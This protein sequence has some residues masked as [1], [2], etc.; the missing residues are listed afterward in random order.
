MKTLKLILS[1]T[2]RVRF[3]IIADGYSAA[4]DSSLP[5][6][7]EGE[8]SNLFSILYALNWIPRKKDSK[9]KFN[10]NDNLDWMIK[11]GILDENKEF[12]TPNMTKLIGKKLYESLFPTKIRDILQIFLGGCS[13][14]TERLHIQIQYAAETIEKCNLSLYPWQLVHDE[15]GFLAKRK[16]VFS[17]LIA[18]GEKKYELKKPKQGR[19]LLIS[20]EATDGK[21][22]KIKSKKPIIL[23]GINQSEYINIR[24]RLS[25]VSWITDSKKHTFEE[26]SQYLIQHSKDPERPNII[27][28]DGHGV[29]K[30]RCRNP[31]CSKF[32]PRDTLKCSACDWTLPAPKG[33]L[34]FENK[35]GK[36]D[37]RSAQTF[38]NVIQKVRPVLVVIQGYFILKMRL[39]VSKPYLHR[40][41]V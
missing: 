10:T 16:V 3:S 27:H 41:S 26:L 17:H 8:E 9:P 35:L 5:Y 32:C 12:F 6:S 34:L 21:M 19:I 38:A 25:L 1:A 2:D 13:S 29:F 36:P 11:E 28:F 39:S 24:D 4:E 22:Q 15:E 37:Y 23:E 14:A 33:F 18:F 40:R 20:S 31:N 30:R 7:D